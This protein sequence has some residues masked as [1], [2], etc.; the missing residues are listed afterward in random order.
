MG[1]ER[2]EIKPF[3]GSDGGHAGA[4]VGAWNAHAVNGGFSDPRKP[5]NGL[6][7]LRGGDVLALPAKRVANSIDEIEIAVLVLPHQIAR[8]EPRVSRLEHIAQ[9]LS[10]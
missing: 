9:D 1:P 3:I 6:R 7:H 10:F 4:A 8:P 2:G 5:A